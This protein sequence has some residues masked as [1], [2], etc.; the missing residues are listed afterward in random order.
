MSQF[1]R[2]EILYGQG[3]Q[4]ILSKKRI[5]LFGLGGV[6]GACLEF[7]LR[8]GL[9]NFTLVDYDR[10]DETNLNRQLIA[11]RDNIGNLKTEEFA[12][13]AR[14]INPNVRI[15]IIN[16]K[17]E[18]DSACIKALNLK[19]YDYIID[20]IDSLDAKLA[21][22]EE[23]YFNNIMIISAMGAGFKF[24]PMAFIIDDI[25]KTSY[26]RL[27][28]RMRRELKSRGVKKLKV[29]Y[30]REK[31][32]GKYMKPVG[33]SPFVPPASGLLIASEVVKDLLK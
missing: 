30:S 16:K 10:I 1:E 19:S 33:S 6:G 11:R 14:L 7:L 21:L 13:R 3:Y 20:C 24:N 31:Y 23:A 4:R 15:E 9:E 12:K 2:S 28:R 25:Y 26:D 17:I 22:A 18:D 5:I 32:E 27:A 8:A 29:C